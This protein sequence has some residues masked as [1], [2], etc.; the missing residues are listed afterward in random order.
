MEPIA[1]LAL[2]IKQ[3]ELDSRLL[4]A[5]YLLNSG[6]AVVFGQQWS[7]FANSAALP[8]GVVLFKTVNAIQAANM[9]NFRAAGH[10]VTAT[11]EEVLCCHKDDQCFLEVFSPT[12]ADNCDLF[13][14]QSDA[15]KGAI[16]RAFPKL[17]GKTRVTGNTRIDFLAPS[18]LAIHRQEA[19]QIVRQY[20]PYVLFNTNYGQ[21]N[22]IWRSMDDVVQIAGKAGM[23]NLMDPKSVEEYKAKLEWERRNC[24]EM[25]NLMVWSIKNCP[26]HKIILRPHPS[27][28][29]D[30]WREQFQGQSDRFVVIPRS[31]PH[32]WLLGADLVVHTTCTTGLEAKILGRPIVNLAPLRHP[33]FDYITDWSMPTF[34]TWQDAAAAIS[35][36][37]DRNKGPIVENED[38]YDQVLTDHFW[39]YK[40]GSAA[41]RVAQAMKELLK[42]H[43]SRSIREFKPYFRQP[44]FRT[45]ARN[46]TLRDKFTLSQDELI[47]RIKQVLALAGLKVNINLSQLDDSV[48]LLFPK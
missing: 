11:D 43:D 22:S 25:I 9:A 14:A 24:K 38:K 17:A 13:F 19:E 34:T 18:R 7:I 44:G 37:L 32:P 26:R 2:E 5:A 23:V 10:L 31:N 46:D 48:F 4:V 16:E 33:T 6:V 35:E 36:F 3:R 39:K 28:R 20:G 30:Y 27:E 41:A 47:G 1:Y 21:T 42:S 15:H 12:A 8:P 40:E 29:V 45:Y